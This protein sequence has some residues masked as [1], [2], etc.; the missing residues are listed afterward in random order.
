MAC[1]LLKARETRTGDDS[2][3]AQDLESDDGLDT[4]DDVNFNVEDN[5]DVVLGGRYRVAS[6]LGKVW[7]GSK[8][9]HEF[10]CVTQA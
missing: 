1:T 3:I 5:I 4:P 8:H 6:A 2:G 7:H 10:D 9:Q